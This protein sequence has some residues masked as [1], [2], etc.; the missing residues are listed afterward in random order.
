MSCHVCVGPPPPPPVP[1]PPPPGE[2][3]AVEGAF[4]YTIWFKRFFHPMTSLE[5]AEG[6]PG[7]QEVYGEKETR[8]VLSRMHIG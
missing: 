8:W 7:A 1:P 4:G 2:Y 5:A 6:V 3:G